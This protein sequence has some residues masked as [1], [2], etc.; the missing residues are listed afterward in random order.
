MA[1]L[2]ILA[3]VMFIGGKRLNLESAAGSEL[4]RR[5]GGA[6]LRRVTAWI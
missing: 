5:D 1:A 4:R 6:R 3:I 2:R